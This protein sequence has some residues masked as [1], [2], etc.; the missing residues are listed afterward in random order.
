MKLLLIAV[1]GGIYG[2]LI[3]LFYVAF[4]SNKIQGLGL[5]KIIGTLA[6][7]TIG[8]WFIAEPFQYIAGIFPPYWTAKAYWLALENHSRWWY[9]LPIGFIT[10]LLVLVLLVQRFSKIIYL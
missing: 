4:A 9:P 2:S 10:H 6:L 1:S 7:I 8:V 5:T 3:A